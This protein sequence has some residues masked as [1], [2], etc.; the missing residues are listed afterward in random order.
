MDA[1]KIVGVSID[2]ENVIV[3]VIDEH[4]NVDE[5]VKNNVIDAIAGTVDDGE[6]CR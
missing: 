6:N 5:D 4:D 2:V 3:N 1:E